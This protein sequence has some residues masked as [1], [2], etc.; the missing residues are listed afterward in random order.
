ML[1]SEKIYQKDRQ[2]KQRHVLG[3]SGGKDSAALAIYLHDKVP[4]MEYFFCDT[5]KELDE[6]YE[7]LDKLKARLGI[8]IEYLSADKG[9]D[10]WLELYNG[11]LPSAQQRWC[12]IQMKIKPL[13]AFIGDDEAIT[14]VGIRADENREGYISKKS[15]IRPRY[16]F[17]YDGIEK[18]DVIRI[19]D[20]SGIGMP[21]YYQ[22]RSRSGCY[23]CF[24]QRKYEWV[25]LAKNHP[26]LFEKA[27]AYEQKH[28]D[29][30]TYNWVEG[31]T[32]DELLLRKDRIISDN[33]KRVARESKN[34]PN[35]PLHEVLADVLDEEDDEVP[36]LM[37]TT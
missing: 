35:K 4:D 8:H 5:H 27:K 3:L 31:E 30:R 13:E 15:N 14:Y 18:P 16:P 19:L 21:A 22:W 2:K 24:F 12:T 26:D 28:S 9:F 11:F 36:C 34:K 23:F 1:A 7:F 20:E 37:C 17:M 32:L 29:G 33:Q 25:M 10:H 6:T